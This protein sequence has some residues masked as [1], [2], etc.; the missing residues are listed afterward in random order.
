MQDSGVA[1]DGTCLVCPRL[2]VVDPAP[3][4]VIV[5]TAHWAV[6]HAF[7]ANLEGW[8]VVL[9]RRHV[10]ALDELEPPEADELGG[11]LR[12]LTRALRAVV[13]CEKTYVL[14]LAESEGYHHVH[15]H[16]VPRGADLDPSRRG[17]GIFGLLGNPDLDVVPPERRDELALAVRARLVADGAIR[18]T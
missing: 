11:L 12:G 17:P 2:A 5:R 13:G 15:F 1:D 8:L 9:S 4:D 3:R 10:Q 18:V 14:L 16:V 7:N 6:A